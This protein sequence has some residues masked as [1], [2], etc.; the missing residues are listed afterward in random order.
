MID[1]SVK[2][3]KHNDISVVKRCC[4]SRAD[5][6]IHYEI[7]SELDSKYLVCE[8]CLQKEIWASDILTKEVIFHG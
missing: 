4:D 8:G 1:N 2:E 6:L 7:T 3:F 5:F